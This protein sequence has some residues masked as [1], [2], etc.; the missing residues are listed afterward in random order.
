MTLHNEPLANFDAARL[1]RVYHVLANAVEAGAIPGAAIQ[2]ISHGRLLP[3]RAFGAQRSG[4]PTTPDTI[5][6]TAS[7]T[8]PMTVTA[9][10]IL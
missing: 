1:D 4:Q 10:M 5:F 8:K 3:P 2:L 9:A 6:L 7:V